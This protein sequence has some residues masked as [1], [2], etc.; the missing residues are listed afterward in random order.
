MFP[1]A[2]PVRVAAL[3]AAAGLVLVTAACAVDA[4]AGGAAPVPTPSAGTAVSTAQTTAAAVATQ[5]AGLTP[6]GFLPKVIGQQAG[7]D[8]PGSTIDSC[9]VK[10]QV[11]AL[12]T[13]PQCAQYGRAPAEGRKTLLL[14]VLMTT[15]TLTTD[16][17][18]AAPAI[19]APFSLK[20]IGADGFVHD[21][22]PGNCTGQ[23]GALSA[24]ILPNSK[25]EGTVEIEVPE[26]VTSVAS[27]HQPARDG[28]RGWVWPVG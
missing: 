12:E 11:T 14:R 23:E 22:Q 17:A 25:Y 10:F 8:C 21:A 28:S 5:K 24:T 18:G 7:W 16:G 13:N 1:A 19:F 27:A 6:Q 4:T 20:G 2:R 9:G 3:L 15:G 26:S